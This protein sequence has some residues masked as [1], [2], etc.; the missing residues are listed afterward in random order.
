[1]NN[2]FRITAYHP[3][4]NVG[5][6]IDSNGKFT[7]LGDFSLHLLNK[8][9]KIMQIGRA[10]NFQDGNITKIEPTEELVVRACTFGK[11]ERNDGVIT[12][13][14]KFYKQQIKK[15]KSLKKRQKQL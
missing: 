14:G 1:M 3:T 11:P 7:S 6:I 9:C 2:Y 15:L 4:S 13:N 8:G 12:V 10:E 5:F